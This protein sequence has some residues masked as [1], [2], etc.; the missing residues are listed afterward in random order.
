MSRSP[1]P[2]RPLDGTAALVTGG[3][4]GIGLACARRLAA[5]GAVVTVCGRTE[6][7]LKETG[8]RHTVAD[9]TD[10]E[11]VAAAVAHAAGPAPLRA[12]VHSAG[13]TT[14]IG[15]LPQLD[16]DAWRATLELNATGTML[17]LKH[18]A[19]VMAR[20]GGGSFVAISSIAA[21]VTHR[22]F[23][24]YGVSKAAVDHLVRL[25]A[26][27]LGGAGVR[28]NGIRPGL[29]RTEL[30]AGVADPGPVLDDY[31][32]CMPLGRVGEPADIA[33]AAR[34][35]AG[36]E[37]SWLTGQVIDVDGGHHLRRGPDYRAMFEPMFGADALRGVIPGE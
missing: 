4:S 33:E 6:S 7:R 10:E 18:A 24:A 29:V 2:A 15:P 17:V 23:G 12:V 25:G 22:W 28:V 8:L 3:G 37:S 30:V 20:S 31:L 19:R 9:V 11:Q 13:G 34:F 21:A 26:D 5:D 27:E 32:A 16:A 35:L 1:T 14:S 36:P